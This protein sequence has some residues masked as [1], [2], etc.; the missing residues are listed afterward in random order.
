M[1]LQVAVSTT[2]R[3]TGGRMKGTVLSALGQALGRGEYRGFRKQPGQGQNSLFG[4]D[5]REWKL[6]Q[7]NF[8]QRECV[9]AQEPMSRSRLVATPGQSHSHPKI[10]TAR[11]G[12]GGGGVRGGKV[13]GRGGG[14]MV[15][16]D[17]EKRNLGRR[18]GLK[19][20]GQ[21]EQE[22]IRQEEKSQD[23]E[24]HL[25]GSEGTVERVGP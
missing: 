2:A 16:L 10:K 21:D 11:G 15:R 4:Q 9:I 22:A 12:R 8:H 17:S 7:I 13:G 1:A 24:Q 6:D 5:E 20:F 3:G 25:V 23:R 14:K 18:G 19:G